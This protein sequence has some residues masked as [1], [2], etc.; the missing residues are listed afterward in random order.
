MMIEIF[1]KIAGVLIVPI[2]LV[3]LNNRLAKLKHDREIK[4]EFL[5]LAEDLE[6]KDLDKR[7]TLYKD[8]LAKS[9]FNDDAITYSE[10]KF[11][12]K[13]ENADSW[14][15]QYANIRRKLKRNRDETGE[16]I[17]FEPKYNRLKVSLAIVGYVLFALIGLTPF[18]KF[19]KYIDWIVDYYEKGM[20]LNVF[21]IV[22]LHVICLIAGFWCLKYAERCADSGI[23]LHDFY[24]DAFEVKSI[25]ENDYSDEDKAA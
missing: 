24:K 9:A 22:A 5:K 20:F 1:L 17:G 23:F 2:L 18:Y 8:R 16:I 12:M 15:S 3:F 7:S 10:V 11:F 21:I 6:S 14:V 25:K 19:Y 4:A 13:Y